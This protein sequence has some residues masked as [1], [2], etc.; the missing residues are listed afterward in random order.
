M[1][2]KPYLPENIKKSSLNPTD[3]EIFHNSAGF[4]YV[5]QALLKAIDVLKREVL[6]QRQ[7]KEE[8]EAKVREEVCTEMMEVINRMQGDFRYLVLLWIRERIYI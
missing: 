5:G 1:S 4:G 8:L 6:R 3:S 7:E 2:Q